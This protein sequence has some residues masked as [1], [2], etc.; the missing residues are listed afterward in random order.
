MTQ[1]E[2]F[3]AALSPFEKKVFEE[4]IMGK[5]YSNIAKSLKK[6]CHTVDDALLRIRKKFTRAVI[7]NKS[8]IKTVEGRYLFP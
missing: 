8:M 4:L 3:Y 1:L 7:Q 5:T 6:E 2:K